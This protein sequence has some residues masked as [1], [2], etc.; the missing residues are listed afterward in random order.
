MNRLEH[1]DPGTYTNTR[2]DNH[3]TRNHQISECRGNWIFANCILLEMIDMKF[4]LVS[5][6]CRYFHSFHGLSIPRWFLLCSVLS[7]MKVC[8]VWRCSR[9]KRC[10]IWNLIS[11]LCLKLG[12]VICYITLVGLVVLVIGR[13]RKSLQGKFCR[14]IR[15]TNWGLE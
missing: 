8:F 2:K 15:R 13:N 14:K 11:S 9:P 1:R 3:N 10:C 4:V 7:I 12:V 6:P 5:D